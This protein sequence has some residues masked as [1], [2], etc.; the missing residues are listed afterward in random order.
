M[1]RIKGRKQPVR[2]PLLLVSY[3]PL[4]FPKAT[5]QSTRLFHIFYI[6]Y[7]GGVSTLRDV[8]PFTDSVRVE[9]DDGLNN[10]D[11]SA[12]RRDIV[13]VG[14]GESREI[15]PSRQISRRRSEQDTT[16]EGK[17]KICERKT[18]VIHER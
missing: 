8:M 7:V 14:N 1:Q 3:Q 9:S 4:S 11:G 5:L 10:P 18:L 13:N 6:S 12:S 15:G 2:V 16:D 17:S